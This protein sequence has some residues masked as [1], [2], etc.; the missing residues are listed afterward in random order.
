MV[1]N[2]RFGVGF[3]EVKPTQIPEP[4]VS[5]LGKPMKVQRVKTQNIR[6]TEKKP[7]S[8]MARGGLS[9]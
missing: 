6:Y 7:A 9:R 1:K 2:L 5:R 4:R 8:K 3:F